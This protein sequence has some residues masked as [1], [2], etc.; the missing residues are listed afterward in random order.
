MTLRKAQSN[1]APKKRGR[2]PKLAN[3]HKNGEFLTGARAASSVTRTS[4]GLRDVLFLEIEAL[5]SGEC[6]PN[7]AMATA[8]LAQ[9][10]INSV[11]VEIEFATKFQTEG[12]D[13]KMPPALQLSGDVATKA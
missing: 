7:R 5:R 3:G 4:S 6:E 8:K 13:S 2:P 11:R 10:I 12:K 1:V 9:Q